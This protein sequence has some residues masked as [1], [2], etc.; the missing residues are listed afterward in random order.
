MAEEEKKVETPK[1]FEK[2]VASWI[3]CQLW[4]SVSLLSFSKSTGE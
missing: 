4:T 3:K 1:E 2:L